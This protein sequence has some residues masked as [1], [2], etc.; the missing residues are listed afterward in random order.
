[1]TGVI[2]DVFNFSN[3]V[4]KGTNKHFNKTSTLSNKS[5][6]YLMASCIGLFYWQYKMRGNPLRTK[7]LGER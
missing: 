4:I 3:I 2:T 6:K 7:S 1:M 5:N